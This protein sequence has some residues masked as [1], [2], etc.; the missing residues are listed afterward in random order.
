MNEFSNVTEY[1]VTKTRS[2]FF[3]I[4]KIAVPIFD[5]IL[6]VTISHLISV[7][8]GYIPG[9]AAFALF[10]IFSVVYCRTYFKRIDYDYRIVGNE[11]YFSVV[12]N[13]K[14]RKELGGVDITK[15]EAI[16]PY[17]G[18]YLEEAEKETYDKIY[19]YS[20]SP[21]DPYVYYAV[22]YDD[23]IKTKTLYLFNASEKMLKQIKFYNRRAIIS[24]PR[25]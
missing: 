7:N 4:C 14:R 20:S 25:E 2:S 10:V 24:L 12:Y 21:T 17:E 13:R 15:L 16:A 18:K 5:A 3:N 9:A 22:S 6:S 8:F 11:L 19:D 23:E 1:S